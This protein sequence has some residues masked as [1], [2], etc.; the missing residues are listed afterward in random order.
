ML[1]GCNSDETESSIFEEIRT[2]PVVELEFAKQQENEPLFVDN[3]GT[4]T[5][6]ADMNI[7]PSDEEFSQE[8]LYRF[9]YNPQ[10]KVIDGQEIVVL[11]VSSAIE[12]DGVTYVPEDGVSYEAILEWAEGVYNY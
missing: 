2:A 9:T 8:W 4:T 1:S 6:I 5:S 12:I 10:E 11:F 3:A 7:I